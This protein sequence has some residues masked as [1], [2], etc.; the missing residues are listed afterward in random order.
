LNNPIFPVIGGQHKEYII[1]QLDDFR[2][3]RRETDMSGTMPILANRMSEAETEAIADYLDGIG[4][5]SNSPPVEAIASEDNFVNLVED[6]PALIALANFATDSARLRSATLKQLD[7]VVEYAKIFPDVIF[8]IVGYTDSTGPLKF[9]AKLSLDRA[10]SVSKYMIHKGISVSRI[11]IKG[12]ASAAPIA[13]NKTVRG[14]A[15][16]RR[17]EIRS[18]GFEINHS[19]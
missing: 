6:R 8:D 1:K 12:E 5:I 2:T 14:R 4:P 17:V 11:S 13:D 3:G 7:E 15:K 19:K 10:E 18:P 9:N 16:N